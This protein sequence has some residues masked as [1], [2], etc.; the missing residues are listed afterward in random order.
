MSYEAQTTPSNIRVLVNLYTHN[1]VRVSWHGVLS[2]YFLAVNGVKQ[3]A[4]LSPILFCVYIDDLLL[5]LA[6]AGV[7]C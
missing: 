4:V 7:G 5:L 6:N 3:G 1:F 2:D